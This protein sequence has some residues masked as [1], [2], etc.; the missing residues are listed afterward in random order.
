MERQRVYDMAKSN[1]LILEN[2]LVGAADGFNA[3]KT[4]EEIVKMCANGELQ[5]FS[6]YGEEN[7][8]INMC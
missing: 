5:S 8:G 7:T 6:V 3:G 4:E 2:E 1:N